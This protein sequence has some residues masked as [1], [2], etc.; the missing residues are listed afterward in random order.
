MTVTEG[1][2]A[3]I[4][5]GEQWMENISTRAELAAQYASFEKSLSFS[6]TL[7]IYWRSIAWVLY[8]LAVVFGYGIDGVVASN[9]ISIPIFREHYGER[10]DTTGTVSYIIS[11]TWLA[12]FNGVS[13]ATAVLGAFAAGYLA[14]KIGRKY[15]S[16][17]S[18]LISMGGVTAQYASN[19]SLP[20]IT[21]GKA[22]NGIPVGM[23]LVIG[24]LYASEVAPLKLRGWLVAMT[25]IVQFSGV[26]LFTGVIY[27]LGPQASDLAYK[28]PIA[29]QWIVPAL[30]IPTVFMWPESPVWL[31]R[32]GRR[33]EALQS[34]SRLYGNNGLIRHEG[35]LAQIE[36]S[37]AKE[38]ETSNNARKGDIYIECFRAANRHRTLICMFIYMCQYLSGLVFVLGYQSYYYQLAGFNPRK[39]FLLSMLNNGSMF[40]ANICSWFLLST[41]GRRPLIVWG[42]LCGAACLLIIAGCSM[43]ESRAGYHAAIAFIFVWGFTY[44]L[45]LGTAAWTVVGEIPTLRLRSPTQGLSNMALCICQWA[46][47]FVFPYLFNPDSANL[48]GKVGFIFGATSFI[49]FVVVYFYLPET[50]NKTPL[51]LDAIFEKRVTGE[52]G[53]SRTGQDSSSLRP[54]EEV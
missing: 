13:Q 54:A 12:V 38:D 45:T 21:A 30:V 33:N 1:A 41:L 26:L 39:S 40:V 18:C 32:M 7:R 15:T 43:L 9:L 28:V 34:I 42:Q 10:F 5:E 3:S 52:S 22:I 48:Q 47:G 4:K 46:V 8:G 20:V 35:L 17:I 29:C 24:P 51:E 2:T 6:Q 53:R 25:N 19:G 27:E 37:T 36:E 16:L 31:V 11:A 44:Q 23:W 14:E 50:K 49:G